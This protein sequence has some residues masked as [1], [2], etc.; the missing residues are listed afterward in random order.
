MGGRQGRGTAKINEL[1][2]QSD[3]F[4]QAWYTRCKLM[5]KAYLLAYT[6]NASGG[7]LN[8]WVSNIWAGG[9]DSSGSKHG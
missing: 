6:R 4:P 5:F 2:N 1:R 8:Q 3:D 9:D 7:F